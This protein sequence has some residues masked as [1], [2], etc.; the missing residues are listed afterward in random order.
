MI[1]DALSFEQI[2]TRLV[3]SANF[4]P[5]VE[6][7]TTPAPPV[8]ATRTFAPPLPPPVS[9]AVSAATTN[10][11]GSL[12][13]VGIG[14][15]LIAPSST[16][17]SFGAV[18]ALQ[19]SLAAIRMRRRCADLAD[20]SP[21][22]DGVAA[23]AANIAENP[24]TL[25][26]AG[27]GNDNA[28]AGGSIVGNA[29]LVL[30]VG[31]ALHLLAVFV[32][33]ALARWTRPIQPGQNTSTPRAPT[34]P[35]VGRFVLGL[36]GKDMLPGVL[37][38]PYAAVVQPSITSAVVLLASP[39][40][41]V[42][43][44]GAVVL[45][46]VGLILWLSPIVL[47]G[48]QLQR[49][50]MK[51]MV[52]CTTHPQRA[53]RKQKNSSGCEVWLQRMRPFLGPLELWIPKH[54]QAHGVS[55]AHIICKEHQFGPMFLSF[56]QHAYWFLLVETSFAAIS[57]V[58]GGAASSVPDADACDA[59]QWGGWLLVVAAAAQLGVHGVLRPMNSR[60][61][62]MVALVGDVLAVVGNLCAVLD[63]IA[64]ATYLALATSC[65][66]LVASFFLV[67]VAVFELM[68]ESSSG[69]HSLFMLV[70]SRRTVQHDTDPP[71]AALSNT[72]NHFAAQI[73]ELLAAK[74]NGKAVTD[75]LSKLIR[76]ACNHRQ[77]GISADPVDKQRRTV[78]V[79]HANPS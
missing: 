41:S 43:F 21:S 24:T 59:A 28:A 4:T 76:I 20:P 16:L 68:L 79:G 57:A 61:D 27:L 1:G 10:A 39:R 14:G 19:A 45:G 42:A 78:R 44:Q 51:P 17:G 46:A 60:F 22:G 26:L 3:G 55:S 49:P 64:A 67:V 62:L 52:W 50:P 15:S 31:G 23:F 58:I 74:R 72:T 25:E 13:W 66:V 33:P 32:R 29:A 56:R 18:A 71:A 9:A 40:T 37:V 54:N 63:A 11:V 65:F 7:P 2:V 53:K 36:V 69:E 47:W 48:Y 75:N 30:C 38:G 12:V 34:V 6:C 77:V 5:S 35:R 8:I 73:T 70:Q